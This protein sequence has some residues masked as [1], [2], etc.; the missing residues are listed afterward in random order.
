MEQNAEYSKVLMKISA[1]IKSIRE[2]RNLTQEDMT[3]FGFNY[4]HYQ[5]LESGTYS[6]SFYT[7]YRLSKALKVSITDL[8]GSG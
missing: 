2:K 1:N 3:K 7:I 6:P 8:I 4:R 5:R